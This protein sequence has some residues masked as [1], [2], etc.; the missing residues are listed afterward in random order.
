M[1][2]VLLLYFLGIVGVITLAPFRF[3]SVPNV[4]Y[5]LQSG[6]WFDNWA[7]IL[8][9]LPLGFLYPLTQTADET[10][11]WKVFLIGLMLSASIEMIQ[12]YEPARYS[13]VFDMTTNAT[14]ALLGAVLYQ[15][16]TRRIRINARLV[17][18]LS[19][20]IPLI[21][22]IYLL[23]PLVLV[24]SLSA[25]EDSSR[26][27]ALLPLV[28]LGSRLMSAVQRYHFGPPRV[29]SNRAM[30]GFA[31]GWV[32][33][34]AFPVVLRH[35]TLG[36]S[37]GVAV[38]LLTWYESS[39][40]TLGASE[41]RFEA[42]T[43]RDARPYLVAYF[44]IVAGMP[45]LFGTSPWHLELGLTGSENDPA[46]QMLRLLEPVA[47]LTLLGYAI[48]EGRGRHERKFRS[49]A[50]RVMLECGVVAVIVEGSR[51]FQP[52]VGASVM[53]WAAM[54]AASVL[55]AGIYHHQRAHVRWI[56]IHRPPTPLSVPVVITTAKG[57]SLGRLARLSEL[58]RL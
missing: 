52:G 47:S 50:P 15:A 20:E 45:L 7:N 9:F 31:A 16:V 26:L 41:R 55:G 29:F 12:A 24:A 27:L 23:V 57:R 43:L 36:L 25:N 22:L 48:A 56:L 32:A 21:G 3:T 13:S 46:R 33:I 53:Q 58:S 40:P 37:V 54:I 42:E 35:P 51:G 17:G 30:G 44:A 6:G 28:L 11:V 18:R 8:M 2:L 19:L 34:G 49:I 38:G 5:L 39:L 1:S 4:S 10:P 14:G